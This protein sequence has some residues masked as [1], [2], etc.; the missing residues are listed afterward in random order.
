MYAAVAQEGALYG[1]ASPLSIA[2]LS[3][4][5]HAHV[6]VRIAAMRSVHLIVPDLF[7]PEN[8]AA[9]VSAGLVLPALERVLARGAHEMLEGGAL[10]TL[11]CGLFLSPDRCNTPVA[12]ISAAF[13][14]LGEGCWLRADPAHMQLRRTHLV[15]LPLAD[16]A[17]DDAVQL[18]AALNAHF[19]GQGMTFA[20]PHPLRWYLR[21]DAQPDIR[22]APISQ[23]GGSDVRGLLPEGAEGARWQ[24]LFNEVQML[25]HAHP[26][27]EVREARGELPVNCLWLWGNGAADIQSSCRYVG[28]SSDEALVGMF[29]AAAGVGF[30]GWPDSWRADDQDG[31]QLLVWTGLR[32]ALQRGDLDGWRAALQEFETGYVQPVWRALRAGDIEHLQLD[33]LG[34]RG[35]R[36]FRLTRADA[37]AIWRRPQRLAEYSMR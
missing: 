26:L 34:E 23:A 24:Q 32:S 16:V 18:C 25:L 29:A 9:E 7:L 19:A 14:G 8:I 35:M 3:S 27:N 1:A 12:A 28:V 20:A 6:D 22:T 30:A 5:E 2:K 37:W 36:H 4:A 21:L 31:E 13:D 11:L 10:E 15:L 17:A 33:V